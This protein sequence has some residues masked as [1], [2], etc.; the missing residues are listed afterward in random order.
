[1]QTTIY[2]LLIYLENTCVHSQYTV[3]V[4]YNHGRPSIQRVTF[5]QSSYE[6]M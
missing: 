2:I 5:Y 3:T 1:M 4:T 6:S